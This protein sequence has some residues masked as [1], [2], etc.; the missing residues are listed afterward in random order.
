MART[1][2]WPPVPVNG[3]IPFVQGVD[4]TN[5]LIINVLSDL[6]AQPFNDDQLSLGNLTWRTEST[7]T[8]RITGAL[9]R[10]KTIISINNIDEKRDEDGGA[11]TYLIEYFDRE[12]RSESEVTFG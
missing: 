1:M 7:A 2:K 12:T 8:G 11:S 3:R 10:L 9:D 6:Q 5:V 4:A